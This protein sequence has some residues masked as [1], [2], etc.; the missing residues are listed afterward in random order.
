MPASAPQGREGPCV[1]VQHP[2]DAAQQPM[3]L[4]M[5]I[6]GVATAGLGSGWG[7]RFQSLEARVGACGSDFLAAMGR[8]PETSVASTRAPSESCVAAR[9]SRGPLRRGQTP[10]SQWQRGSL[11]HSASLL[12]R[13]DQ[14]RSFATRG[15]GVLAAMGRL[16]ETSPMASTRAPS[17]S[18]VAARRSRGP[19]RRGRR[20]LRQWQRGPL[21]HCRGPAP[22]PGS[23]TLW[24]ARLT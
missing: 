3:A 20:P 1:Q 6:N 10:L 18:C 11:R 19:L 15:S 12:G 17:A 8:L 9:Q 5:D 14:R 16:P 4:S 23:G 24:G 21:R 2:G 13:G 22:S 7:H